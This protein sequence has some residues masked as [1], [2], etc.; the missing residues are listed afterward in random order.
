MEHDKEDIT[1]FCWTFPT[2]CPKFKCYTLPVFINVSGLIY[3]TRNTTL[4]KYPNTLLGDHRKL[5]AYFCPCRNEYYFDRHRESF[6]SILFFYQSSGKLYRPQDINLKTFLDE[7]VFFEL[8]KSAINSMKRKEGGFLQDEIVSFLSPTEESTVLT[9]RQRLWNFFEEPASSI[10]ARYFSYLAVCLLFVSIIVNCLKTV[11]EIR[12]A[13]GQLGHDHDEWEITDIFLNSYFLL[14]FVI[15]LIICPSKILFFKNVLVWIDFIAL[16]TF[17]PVMNKHYTSD[18]VI[19]F[20]TPFQIFRVVRI[21]RLAKLLP[22]YNVTEIILKDC[23]GYFRMF[24]TWLV[25]VATAAATLIYTLE[26]SQD[27]TH[28]KSVA[29]GLYWAI[30]TAVTLGY[31][32][33]YPTSSLGK[34][35]ATCFILTFVP[36]LCLPSLTILVRFAKYY[37]FAKAMSDE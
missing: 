8:P 25:F 1:T 33:I 13:S 37:E 4:T 7:C 15:R 2:K 29:D 18:S 31:G 17:I 5:S 30:Q 22:E 11:K 19:L 6:S 27:E 14:E 24:I 9:L 3:E 23:I 35:F 10:Y 21:V 28:F 16:I 36:T 20:F 26:E 34:L 12:P 32:D